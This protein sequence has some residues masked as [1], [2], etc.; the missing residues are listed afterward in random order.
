LVD[1]QSGLREAVALLEEYDE[2]QIV[3]VCMAELAGAY[4][5]SGN[6]F[7]ASEWMARSDARQRGA[8]RLFDAWVEL[9]RAWVHAAA[10]GRPAAVDATRRAAGLARRT[11]QPTYEATALY[12]AARLGAATAVRERLST[13]AAELDT[14]VAR[15]MAAAAAALA[16][17]DPAALETAAV[18]MTD[19]GHLLLGAE[20]WATAARLH[21]VAGQPVR[22]RGALERAAAL[23]AACQGARTPLMDVSG[24]GAHLT[25]REREIASLAAE[26][27]SRQIAERLGLS[28]HTVNNALA[29]VFTKLGVTNRRDL[30]T[31]LGEQQRQ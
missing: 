24:L 11:Q 2:Y 6:A 25:R 26:L 19:R 1:A 7:A 8:N 29:R 18:T 21:S 17:G 5:L 14:P 22:S 13:V 23:S 31:V 28:V 3:R 16:S 15:A 20:A 12:Q 9:D 27:P 10:G 4:A 30:R